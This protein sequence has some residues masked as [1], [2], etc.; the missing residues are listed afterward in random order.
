MLNPVV[1]FNPDADAIS[2]QILNWI[3]NLFDNVKYH[4][5]KIYNTHVNKL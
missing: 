5:Q 4:I 3:D 1:V 2:G